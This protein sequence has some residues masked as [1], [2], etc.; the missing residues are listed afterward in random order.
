MR[1]YRQVLLDEPVRWT[2]KPFYRRY[3]SGG[4]CLSWGKWTL[5]VGP[6]QEFGA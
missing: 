4:F 1:K 2:W 5:S 3:K 6:W